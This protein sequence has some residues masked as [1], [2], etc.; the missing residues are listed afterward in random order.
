[1]SP[2]PVALRSTGG[3]S[4]AEQSP[5]VQGLPVPWTSF[6]PSQPGSSN[7]CQAP[8]RAQRC[9]RAASASSWPPNRTGWA[10]INTHLAGAAALRSLLREEAVLASAGRSL[11]RAGRREATWLSLCRRRQAGDGQGHPTP[12]DGFGFPPNASARLCSE[13]GHS[14]TNGIRGM[15]HH[16]GDP[17]GDTAGDLSP[18]HQCALAPS[19]P[20]TGLSSSTAPACGCPWGDAD[21]PGFGF[22]E[23]SEGSLSIGG[24]GCLEPGGLGRQ[25]TP[26]VCRLSAET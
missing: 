20:W 15:T 19:P 12:S 4:A 7:T 9:A 22:P 25:F 23:E 26:C 2:C 5:I 17:H 13:G 18:E 1:M 11:P 14:P 10:K 3:S 21:A 8:P 16:S 6:Q 24:R